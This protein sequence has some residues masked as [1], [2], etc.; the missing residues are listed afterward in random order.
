MHVFS[1][2]ASVSEEAF[3][4]FTLQ[5]CWDSWMSAMND[6][7]KPDITTVKY[8]NTANRSNIKYQGWDVDGLK[9]FSD[10]ASL[11]KSQCNQQYRRQTEQ[12][13]KNHVQNKLNC[14]YGIIT[15]IPSEN[16][17]SYIAY[18]DSSSDEDESVSTVQNQATN[19]NHNF[20]ELD[21][22]QCD[23]LNDNIETQMNAPTQEMVNDDGELI[24]KC[25]Q[26]DLIQN[27]LNTITCFCI[28]CRL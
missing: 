9:E 12:N 26:F 7:E 2:V 16:I 17:E 10:I 24:C 22:N 4:I 14:M 1:V 18:N 21:N 27:M 23:M 6:T 3:D 25:L 5:R 13:Y 20:A 11:I 8:K 19:A 15:D 28:I